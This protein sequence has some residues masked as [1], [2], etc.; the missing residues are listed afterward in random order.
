MRMTLSEALCD[1]LVAVEVGLCQLLPYLDTSGRQLLLWDPCRHRREG[2][3]GTL[4][5][6]V[7]VVSSCLSSFKMYTLVRLWVFFMNTGAHTL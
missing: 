4:E 7:S 1:D 3:S 6:M 2:Y 5:S